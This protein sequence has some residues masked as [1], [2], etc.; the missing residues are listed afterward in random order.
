MIQQSKNRPPKI[1]QQFPCG[2]IIKRNQR[3]YQFYLCHRSAWRVY[4]IW[5]ITYWINTKTPDSEMCVITSELWNLS[6]R[7]LKSVIT[8][9]FK[10]KKKEFTLINFSRLKPRG[11][12]YFVSRDRISILVTCEYLSL[13]FKHLK[14]IALSFV[15]G[16]W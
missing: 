14:V 16:T 10:K 11:T 4:R 15:N 7:P 8:F 5:R 3:K 13:F 6:R 12:L 9:V 1:H 2:S